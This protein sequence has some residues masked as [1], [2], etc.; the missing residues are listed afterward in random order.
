MHEGL[1]GIGSLSSGKSLLLCLLSPYHGDSQDL[2][3]EIRINIEHQTGTIF[4]LLSRCM[5]RMSLLP[6]E[7]PGAEERPGGLL[8]AYYR[9]PLVIA[10]G[11]I[12]VG[13][14]NS[15]IV[16]AEQ[17]LGGRPYAKP[18]LELLRA[19]VGDPGH[20]GSKALHVILLLLKQT[21][22]DE[23][24]HVAVLHSCLL[25]SAVQFLLYIFPDRI[26]RRLDDHAALD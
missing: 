25:E 17:G 10:L 12:P 6:Q 8:P 4:G 1:D 18:L 16:I 19:S 9:A 24:G 7:L 3:T 22:S 2:L 13:L 20:L 21:F 15:L 26:A 5:S 11:Q 14:D 23:Y